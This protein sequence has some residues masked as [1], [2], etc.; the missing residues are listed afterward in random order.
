M[1]SKLG[2]PVLVVRRPHAGVGAAR[3]HAMRLLRTDVLVVLDADDL[4]TCGSV[5]SRMK[6]MNAYPE[7]DIVFG[8]VRSF[9]DCVD[10]RPVPLDEPRPAHTVGSM[11]VR[12]TAFE[13]VGPFTAGLRMAE[14]LDW[15]LRARE[16]G[17]GET[18]VNDQVLWRRVHGANNSLVERGS[19]HEFPQVLKAS[20]D[21]RRARQDSSRRAAER[22]E[23]GP[24]TS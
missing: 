14:G 16:L 3:S 23:G 1:A 24:T 5:D 8:H 15:L 4:L 9:T 12:R 6:V 13:R 18:T 22:P 10:G 20:L 21:R 7:V 11:L 2:S 17:L 19:L